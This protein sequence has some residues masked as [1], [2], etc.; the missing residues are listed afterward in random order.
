MLIWQH[1]CVHQ[2]LAAKP[3]LAL[4]KTKKVLNQLHHVTPCKDNFRRKKEKEK[5][6]K[7]ILDLGTYSE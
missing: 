6:N 4:D 2:D 1:E 7:E 3:I 5:R